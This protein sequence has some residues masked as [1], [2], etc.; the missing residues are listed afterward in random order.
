MKQRLLFFGLLVLGIY[1]LCH[2]QEDPR[3][4]EFLKLKKDMSYVEAH[5]YLDQLFPEWQLSKMKNLCGCIGSR[6]EETN[7][8]RT[9]QY[10]YTRKIYEAARV[11]T[12]VDNKATIAKKNSQY[13][14][15]I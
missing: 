4:I 10:M 9:Y 8:T 6:I 5:K 3:I 12:M 7:P 11:D 13:V 2:A 14:E 15:C 1:V